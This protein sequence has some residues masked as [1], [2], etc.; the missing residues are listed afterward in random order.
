MQLAV[1]TKLNKTPPDV[2]LAWVSD[3]LSLWHEANWG[4]ALWNLRGTFGVMDSLCAVV[5]LHPR[6]DRTELVT[7]SLYELRAICR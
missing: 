4:W 1:I 5:L 2:V 6:I 3:F 7:L